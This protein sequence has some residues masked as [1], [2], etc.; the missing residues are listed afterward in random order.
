M[1][2]ALVRFLSILGHP[3]IFAPVVLTLNSL[4]QNQPNAGVSFYYG[5]CIGVAISLL[6][7]ITL[8]Q[9]KRGHYSDFDISNQ[10]QRQNFYPIIISIILLILVAAYI[11]EPD[12]HKIRH[13]L[14]SFLILSIAWPLNHYVKASMHSAFA[15]F[16]AT[17][18]IATSPLLSFTLG[19]IALG[20]CW[21][22]F[23]L[24]KHSVKEIYFGCIL[25]VM[26]SVFDFNL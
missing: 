12:I 11:I 7:A 13:L 6:A 18:P 25:G 19:L 8:V 16:L 23:E 3:Y 14:T 20:I 17:I 26:A 22:R 5:L 2:H 4:G 10:I 15:I 1:R 9:I 24:R 21:S